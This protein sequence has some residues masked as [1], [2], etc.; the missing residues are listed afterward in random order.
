MLTWV[1]D[2]IE[3]SIEPPSRRSRCAGGICVRIK[4]S[5][6]QGHAYQIG[7]ACSLH[8]DHEIGPVGLNR[9]RADAEIVRNLLVGM[10]SHQP[11]EDITFAIRQRREAGLDI[12]ALG[13]TL[14]ISIPFI[15]RRSDGRELAPR[16]RK[17]FLENP[18]RQASSPPRRAGYLHE[19]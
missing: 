15:K 1:K 16:P 6:D 12:A 17:A 5:G 3:A 4:N 14:L 2:D 8:L 7:E 13:L 11:V 18:W 10:S 19:P 9:S